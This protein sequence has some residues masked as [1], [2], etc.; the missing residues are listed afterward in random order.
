MIRGGLAHT[1]LA[2][3]LLR[4]GTITYIKG[5]TYYPARGTN[6]LQGSLPLAQS[7]PNIFVEK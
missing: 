4:P 5:T 2:I 1:R 7:K 6:R 3:P